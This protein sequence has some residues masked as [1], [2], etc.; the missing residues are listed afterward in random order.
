MRS[1][2]LDK[3]I[4]ISRKNSSGTIDL[5]GVIS[6]NGAVAIHMRAE[7]IDST[8]TDQPHGS[9]HVTETILNFRLRYLGNVKVGDAVKYDGRNHEIIGVQEIGRRKSLEIRIIDRG[10]L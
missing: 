7:L 1:G 2:S 10:S 4:Y 8:A 5:N 3:H 6:L 9:G